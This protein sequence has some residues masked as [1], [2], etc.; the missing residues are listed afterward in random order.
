MSPPN[1]PSDPRRRGTI[2]ARGGSLQVRVSA[3][4]APVTGRRSTLT[5]TVHGTDAAA[6]K[7]AEKHL[8]RLLR[9]VDVSRTVESSVSLRD[10][11][12]EW[13]RAAE[14]EESTRRAYPGL[15]DLTL[16]PTFGDLPL[17]DLSPRVLE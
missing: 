7:R 10:V 15:L 2:R 14:L 13:L 4:T 9:R 5:A 6:W 1:T 16:L 3:A 11:S 17:R 8:T 12:G